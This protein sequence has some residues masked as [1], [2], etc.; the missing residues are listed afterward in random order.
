MS[1][2]HRLPVRR[3]IFLDDRG[4]DRGLRVTTHAD[5]GVV[6]LS[7]WHGDKCAASFRL[8]VADTGRLIAML[9]GGLT[10]QVVEQRANLTQTADEA[11]SDS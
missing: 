10:D 11:V 6:I 7:I 1:T 8:P 9:A 3:D 2:V 5:E 4:D